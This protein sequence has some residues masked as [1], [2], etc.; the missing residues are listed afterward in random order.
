MQRLLAAGADASVKTT[1]NE[2]ALQRAAAMG[3]VEIV[4]L[5]GGDPN[6]PALGSMSR[7]VLVKDARE[8]W[9][10]LQREM[11]E[12]DEIWIPEQSAAWTVSTISPSWSRAFR[13]CAMAAAASWW[14]CSTPRRS[15]SSTFIVMAW[16][17][18]SGATVPGTSPGS[19]RSFP[20][21]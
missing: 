17:E 10:F 7:C 6:D 4:V 16:R 18:R 19:R 1:R 12:F 20:A 9:F 21:R 13:G 11:V 14:L 5:L 2:T 8:T 15:A 3:F